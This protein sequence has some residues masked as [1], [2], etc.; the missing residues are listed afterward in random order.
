MARLDTLVEHLG[1]IVAAEGPPPPPAVAEELAE[2]CA[3]LDN[4][5]PEMRPRDEAGRPGGLV[6]LRPE[7]PLVVVPDIHGRADLLVTVLS[8]SFPEYGIDRSLLAMIDEDRAQLLMVGDY[9]HGE[10]RA[11]DRWVHAFEEYLGGYRKHAAIDEEMREN[12]TV[13]RIVAA[14]K[15]AYPDRIHGLKGNHE[16]ITNE[17]RDGNLPFGKFVYEGE[18][19]AEYMGRYYDGAAYEAVYRFEKSLPLLAVAPRTLISHA[20]PARLFETD[21]VIDYRNR[22]EVVYGFTWTDNDAAEQGSVRRMLEHYLPQVQPEDAIYLGG[23]R[24]VPELY[25]LRADGLY[26]Q[27]HNPD[28]FI[29]ALPPTGRVFDPDRDVQELPRSEAIFHGEDR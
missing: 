21:E 16:N 27:I 2:V 3:V 22:E 20:E 11:R 12:L 10:A 19:V 1:R 9:V 5:S 6:Y 15:A 25:R 26:V 18:M 17:N 24:P 28:R 23:H 29:V 8:S 4:E 13:L 7:L 14:I